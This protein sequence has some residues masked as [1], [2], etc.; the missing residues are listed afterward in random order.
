MKRGEL[1]LR[2]YP[3]YAA[4]G[5]TAIDGAVQFYSRVNAL[6]DSTMTVLDFG[7][8]RGR[9]FDL[10]RNPYLR[11][12]ALLRGRARHV[13]GADIDP[14][15]KDNPGLD[16]AVLLAPGGVLPFADDSFDLIVSD[17]TFEHVDDAAMTA[18]E[19][20]RVL[21]PGGWICAR[22]PHRWGVIALGGQLVPNRF[23]A[24]M[25]ERLQPGRQA[26][27]VFA[28]RYRMNT[29]TTLRRLFPTE[30]YV[31]ASYGWKPEPAYHANSGVLLAGFR[32][33]NW[34]TPPSLAPML[35]VFIRKR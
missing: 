8:G 27:D 25:I 13:I 1:L 32:L 24:W 16:E 17:N 22:T 10:E 31:H 5:F 18:S 19:L 12:L 9:A 33:L 35:M 21:K 7:A 30:R 14:V 6:A 15:V 26:H 34:L 11:Q 20:G 4:G 2:T 29:R 28:T 23:H 3:E